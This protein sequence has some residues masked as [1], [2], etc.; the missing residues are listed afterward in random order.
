MSYPTKTLISCISCIFQFFPRSLYEDK[1]NAPPPKKRI[2]SSLTG[3]QE[4]PIPGKLK[5]VSS[6]SSLRSLNVQE[7][8]LNLEQRE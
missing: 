8:K 2:V 4:H 6:V 7:H 3:Q 5:L 1:N